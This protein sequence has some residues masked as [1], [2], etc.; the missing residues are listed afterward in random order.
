MD[1]GFRRN[2]GSRMFSVIETLKTNVCSEESASL[3]IIDL[4]PRLSCQNNLAISITSLGEA[5]FSNY[6]INCDLALGH[7][8]NHEACIC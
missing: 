3:L 2:D 8:V 1:S 4:R 7:N 6:I 5:I